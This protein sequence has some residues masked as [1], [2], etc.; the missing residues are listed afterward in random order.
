[1][2]RDILKV[3][4]LFSS[5]SV[6]VLA[7]HLHETIG[8]ASQSTE[9][10]KILKLQDKVH[11]E[12]LEWETLKG[13]KAEAYYELA[14]EIYHNEEDLQTNVDPITSPWDVSEVYK[15][16]V[17]VHAWVWVPDDAIKARLNT[18]QKDKDV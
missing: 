17:W 2:N 16:G 10:S 11:Q 5:M 1:M 12:L 18:E 7:E 14:R 3:V 4:E 13:P 8:P 6:K 9:M 15:G